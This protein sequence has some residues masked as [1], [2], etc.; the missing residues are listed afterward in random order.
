MALFRPIITSINNLNSISFKATYT[1]PNI[2]IENVD[3]YHDS[4]S[5]ITVSTTDSSILCDFTKYLEGDI[6]ADYN[7]SIPASIYI[8]T[9]GIL[10]LYATLG[11]S[12]F[13]LYMTV[14]GNG[15]RAPQPLIY[16]KGWDSNFNHKNP[17]IY[18]S[19][20]IS[21]SDDVLTKGIQTVTINKKSY[22]HTHINLNSDS[23]VLNEQLSTNSY[24]YVDSSVTSITLYTTKE[25]TSQETR[26]YEKYDSPAEGM[27]CNFDLIQNRTRDL[28]I[29][30]R[31]DVNNVISVSTVKKFDKTLCKEGKRIKFYLYENN[32]IALN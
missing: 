15:K 20:N 9:G 16:E 23:I 11:I 22:N 8:N 18:I 1:S 6:V 5:F 19:N 12:D 30:Q 29:K 25:A 3:R 32:W 14:Y 31:R 10:S 13:T 21:F 2:T 4:V 7:C 26:A 24:Y 17:Y 27:I 28:E